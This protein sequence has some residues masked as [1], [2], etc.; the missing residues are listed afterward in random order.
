MKLIVWLPRATAKL[1]CTCGAAFQFALPTWLALITQVPAPMKL[2]LLPAIEHT[3]LALASMVKATGSPD[4][5]VPVTVYAAPAT[6]AAAGAVEVKLIVWLPGPTANDCWIC[7]AGLKFALPAW[8]ALT[9]QVPADRNVTLLPA[10]AQ[11]LLALAS[12]LK[13]AARPEVAVALTL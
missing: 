2:T 9:T 3:P 13:A 12:M 1:C 10:M 7:G 4:V 8:L 6:T 5:A 11:T